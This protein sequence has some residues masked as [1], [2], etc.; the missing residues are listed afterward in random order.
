MALGAK[1]RQVLRLVIEHALRLGAAGVLAGL[2]VASVLARMLASQLFEVT[3]FDPVTLV[4]T[5]SGLMLVA[6]AASY[7]P[8]RKAT[9]V[10][11]MVALRYE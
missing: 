3:A 10:D 2:I 8:A 5:A 7:G 11:P 6:L 4:V 1:R 9:R